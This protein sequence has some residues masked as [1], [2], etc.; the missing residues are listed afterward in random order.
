MRRSIR[1]SLVL[2]TT[3]STL[4]VLLA[5]GAW[6][7]FGVRTALVRQFDTSLRDDAIVLT[8][9]A[10]VYPARFKFDLE[11]FRS[12]EFMAPSGNAYFQVW[13]DSTLVA[14]RS[15]SL[16]GRDLARFEGSLEAPDF[17]WLDLP[18][19]GRVRA[20]GVRFTPKS[21]DTEEDE[22]KDAGDPVKPSVELAADYRGK[23]A[24]LVLARRMDTIDTFLARLRALLLGLGLGAAAVA[25]AT[26]WLIIRKNLNPLDVLARR[27]AALRPTDVSRIEL[28]SV[29]S[30]IQPVVDRL[31]ELLERIDTAMQRERSFS[32]HVAHELRTPVA[33]LR[34]TL[35]VLRSRPRQSAEYDTATGECLAI[36]QQMQEMVESLLNLYRLEANQIAPC[37]E[38]LDLCESVRASWEGF[39]AVARERGLR[40]ELDL[41]SPVVV[42]SDPGLLNLA[43]RNLLENAVMHSD[44]GGWVHIEAESNNGT[45]T[46]QVRNS[47]AR[48]TPEAVRRVFDPFWRG[49]EARGS[50]G[51]HIGLGLSLVKKIAGILGG[52]VEVASEG[53]E[54]HVILVLD[55]SPSRASSASAPSARPR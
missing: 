14:F 50:S 55:S 36:V 47:G 28:P 46:L 21:D 54:F 13:L 3:L 29:P 7:Y 20:V 45:A 1:T 2:G 34:S 39:E 52:T 22:F 38:S 8:S 27:I 30:E 19:S 31:N 48:L 18:G 25:V 4:L 44:Q 6:V 26:L 23:P 15:P 12:G 9:M 40:S 49:D 5:A 35:E 41:P 11:A 42:S 10:D 53:G 16:E 33:A 43:V 32:A 17:R 37:F 51:A 24:T